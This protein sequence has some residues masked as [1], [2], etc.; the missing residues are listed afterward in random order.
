MQLN[1]YDIKSVTIDL[2]KLIK[3]ITDLLLVI[4]LLKVNKSNISYTVLFKHLGNAF[5]HW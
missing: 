4:S 3:K 5:E 1:T 2:N